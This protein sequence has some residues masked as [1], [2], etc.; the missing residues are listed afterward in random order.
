[1]Q[2]QKAMI[3]ELDENKVKDSFPVQFNPTT[4]KLTLSNKV[5]GAQSQGRQVRQHI[6]PSSTTLTL[7]LIF[8]SADEGST[9][10]PLS[11]RDKT[12]K[13]ERFLVAKGSGNQAGTPPRIRF[14]WGDLVIT[15]V[16]DS[17]I[18][19]FDH[20]AANGTPL[21]AKVSLSI[22]DQDREQELKPIDDS[23]RGAGA[24]GSGA[25]GGLGI[26][27]GLGVSAG[28]GLAAGA[29]I[30]G[31]A[32]ASVGV[33]LGGE[34]AADFAARAGID[35]A[36]WRGLDLAGESSLALSAGAEI[37]FSAGLNASAGLG[38]AA[39]VEAGAG[40]S[41]EASFGLAADPG[42]SA[43]SGVGAGAALASG[44]ALAAAGGVSAAL[45]SVQQLKNQSAEQQARIAFKAPAKALPAAA[46]AAQPQ[47]PAQQRTPLQTSGLPSPGLAAQQPVPR[48]PRADS[49]ASTFGFGVPLRTT[50]G[51]AADSRSAALQGSGAVKAKTASDEPPS[52]HDPT[53]PPWIALPARDRGRAGAD[54]IQ[55]RRQP[56]R[57]CGCSGPCKH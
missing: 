57:P 8:D 2:L 26:S 38:V 19:D 35:S 7:D 28:I 48:P 33:A 18:I 47:P 32:A 52:S 11:V 23:R 39:G 43:V 37:G 42:L 46:P 12:G 25:S 17:L 16:V 6:G 51:A 41:L 36:A 13:L 56:A 30:A 22:K 44:F 20:F 53:I 9:T 24:P 15:G 55:R 4:L 29:G 14:S 49:R 54:Q 5:E 34:S 27:A 1:M 21:R 45:E 50:V 40:A 31:G 3:A 10:E